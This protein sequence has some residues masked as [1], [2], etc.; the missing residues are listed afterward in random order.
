MHADAER[1][2]Q[3]DSHGKVQVGSEAF[4]VMR[5]IGL[6]AVKTLLETYDQIVRVSVHLVQEVAKLKA[7]R[8][9]AQSCT[10][11]VCQR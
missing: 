10:T 6:L 2:E 3:L 7:F 8:W 5:F 11:R 1:E 9:L 4:A